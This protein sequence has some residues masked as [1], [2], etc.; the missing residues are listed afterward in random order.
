MSSGRICGDFRRLNAI[1]IP[2]KYPVPHIHDFSSA[3]A[4]KQVFTKLDLHMAYHQIPIADDDIPKTTVITPFGLFEYTAMTFGLRNA[5]QSFQRYIYR[6]LGD[7]E[8]VFTYIDDILIASSNAEEHENHLRTVFQRL[9]EFSLRI[10]LSKCQFGCSELEF[11]GNKISRDG[12]S[13]TLDK[14]RAITQFPKPK[15]V[16]ELRRFPGMVNFY[17]RSLPHAAEAQAQ[18]QQYLCDSRKNYKR[19]IPW[20]SLTEAAFERVKNDL[21][22]VALLAY[23]SQDAETRLV[24]D[25]SDFGMGA[26]LEQRLD[27]LWKPLAFFSRK[28]SPAQR[29]YSTYDRE[30]TAIYEAIRHFKYF[31]EGQ[32][33]K[34]VTDHKPLIYVFSQRAE[35]SSQRQQRQISFISQFT[36]NIEY[37][38]GPENAVADS[39][40]RIDSIRLP[41][42]FSI[43][44]LAQ[45]QST[46][47]ELK[48]LSSD[49]K[50]SLNVRKIF[51]G[52][53][54]TALYCDLMGETLRP[55]IP[56]ALRKRVFNLFH[57]LA[58]SSA[59][60]TESV[61]RKRYVWP[62]MRR[63]ISD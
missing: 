61:I 48:T 44:E 5:C 42:E 22:N 51:W 7:L 24:T 29:V 59:K 10:N 4:G 40:S 36:T 54:H 56:A 23:P 60:V 28:F 30:L 43:T 57:D 52:P 9:K 11:L 6:A 34:V 27:N 50:C 21:A 16:V 25:A 20:N 17:R 37:L 2:D 53:D 46:D 18:L 31:L 35:K 58:H 63:N 8:Y 39:L 12:I 47:E 38:P 3:F 15:T 14:V 41:T 55:I 33:F 32:I 45:A 62:S 13:P 19:Q 1:T 26:S 49:P